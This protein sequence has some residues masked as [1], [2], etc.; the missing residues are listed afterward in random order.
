[1]QC[2]EEELRQ[3]GKII[4]ALLERAPLSRLQTK[5]A[6]RQIILNLQPELQQGA[7]LAAH[8]GK[9]PTTEEL[10]G[11][12]DALYE[13]DTATISPAFAD[14][15]CDIVG[16][17]SDALKTVNVS[18]PAAFIAAACGVKV[19]KKGARLVTGV[20]GATDIM[21]IMGFSL[22]TPLAV[23]QESLEKYGICYLP[24]ELF[25]QSGWARLILSMRFTST[26]NI[27]G[28]LT[29]PCAKTTSMVI[30]AYAPHICPQMVSILKD[31]GMKAVMSPY[32]MSARHDSTQGIDEVSVCG[33]TT[34]V[35]LADGEVT[36]YTLTP[37]DFG[38]RQ[39]PYEDVASRSHARANVEA[40]LDVLL[41]H[42]D[43]A[44][45]DLF[46]I[47]AACAL[48]VHGLER[49]LKKATALAKEAIADGSAL[50]KLREVIACQGGPAGTKSLAALLAARSRAN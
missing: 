27:I 26:F 15:C 47:N 11:V 49:D 16:T 7:F 46:A 5:E 12:W 21:E 39:W 18:T 50:A 48:R 44:L 3:F 30:G 33:P 32:G 38:I 34:M 28:P 14:E 19:A 42:D 1:M 9:G 35:E 40:I 29:R 41:G 17:G 31:T 10:C 4:S 8:L 13:Y 37:A 45:A 6:Y 43:T 22:Q 2:T 25:L 20:S 36:T 24:G 23:A